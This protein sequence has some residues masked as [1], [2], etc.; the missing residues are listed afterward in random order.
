M[1]LLLS[2]CCL[3]I[4]STPCF[5]ENELTD[6][7]ENILS[8]DNEPY[9]NF[10]FGFSPLDGILG[11][12]Y[13]NKNH[14]FGAAIPGRYSYRYYDKPYQ[15]TKFWGIYLG[16]YSDED[17]D[18]T[19]EGVKFTEAKRSYFGAGMGYRWQW[20]SGWNVSASIALEHLD[21]EYSNPDSPLT[22]TEKVFFLFPGINAGYKF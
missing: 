10:V 8:P 19:L 6:Q 7:T 17:I 13:Q 5:A 15:D 22:A 1:K 3:F 2:V 16:G 12:E 14:S 18:K 21:S 4:F 11:I 20:P 9:F